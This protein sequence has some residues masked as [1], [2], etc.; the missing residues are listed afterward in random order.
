MSSSTDTCSSE[1]KLEAEAIL[2][3]IVADFEQLDRAIDAAITLLDESQS[4]AEEIEA[5]RR[6]RKAA[7]KGAALARSNVGPR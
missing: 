4:S 1:S 2:K 5:L 7:R 3:K 6:A